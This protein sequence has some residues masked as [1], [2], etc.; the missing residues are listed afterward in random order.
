MPPQH[1]SLVTE[2]LFSINSNINIVEICA[3]AD[4]FLPPIR[5]KDIPVNVTCVSVAPTL[6][7]RNNVAE[8]DNTNY[9]IFTNCSAYLTD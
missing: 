3:A 4:L 7:L 9:I 5:N 8:R 1:Q 2:L 6:Y